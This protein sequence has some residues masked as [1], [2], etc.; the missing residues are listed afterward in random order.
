MDFYVYREEGKGLLIFWIYFAFGS[1]HLQ[2]V[3]G[4]G[5][6]LGKS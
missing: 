6:R 4:D 1:G 5:G 2:R 3:I